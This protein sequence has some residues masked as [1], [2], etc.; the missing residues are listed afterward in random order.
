[1]KYIFYFFIFV[2]LCRCNSA[3]KKN[4]QTHFA[5]PR[6]HYPLTTNADSLLF[7]LKKTANDS[8]RINL[9]V[10]LAWQKHKNNTDTSLLLNSQAVKISDSLAS[11][12]D[13]VL[14][15]TGKR[16]QA[17]CLIE[18][19][20]FYY[21]KSD[22]ANA[23]RDYNESMNLWKELQDST[24]EAK[25]LGNIANIYQSQGD[26]AKALTYDFRALAIADKSGDKELR[27]NTL[28]NIGVLYDDQKEY[29]KA[30][31]YLL[32]GLEIA[33]DGGS[34][35]SVGT[36]LNNIG[37][38]YSN[39][40]QFQKA[41]EYYHRSYFID[42]ANGDLS[43]I[44]GDLGNI[45]IVLK[46]QGDSVLLKGDR[47]LALQNYFSP[48]LEIYSRTLQ[49]ADTSGSKLVEANTLGSIGSLYMA[50]DENE[51]AEFYLQKAIAMS[52]E[53]KALAKIKIFEETLSNLYRKE[54]KYQDAL[55]HYVNFSEAKDSI[56]NNDKER[57]VT[58]NEMNYE[59]EKKELEIKNTQDVKNA[60]ALQEKKKQQL[61]IYT[62]SAG[63]LLV[64][65]LAGVILRSLWLNKKKNRVISSQKDILE[66]KQKEILDSIHYAKR[67]QNS[68][69]PNEKYIERNLD[70]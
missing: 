69:L 61:I 31:E 30:L 60:Q 49:I 16:G 12:R 24:G 38:A 5:G 9:L 56:F 37:T 23:L 1:M 53:L 54:G 6:S 52:T 13:S 50:M 8:D 64:L 27:G 15:L 44:C 32:K 63:L 17:K 42:S 29:S 59:F 45:G 46:Q 4:G 41:L 7:F 40:N 22:F 10:E 55:D 67:I 35:N 34:G 19:G 21:F 26:F 2:F 43:R 68:L 58:R 65:L 48:A 28:G 25:V 20:A 33:E 70:K 36:K 3:E 14:M 18:S 62:V 47:S 57:E 66:E 11:S 51:K 39:M